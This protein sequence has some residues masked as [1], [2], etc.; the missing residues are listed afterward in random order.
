MGCYKALRI[1]FGLSF[2]GSL[3]GVG[4]QVSKTPHAKTLTEA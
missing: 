2:L 3:F 1:P 4:L